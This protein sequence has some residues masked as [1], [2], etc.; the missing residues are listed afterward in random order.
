MYVT[1]S[2]DAAVKAKFFNKK[3]KPHSCTWIQKLYSVNC[4][5]KK[6]RFK[7]RNWAVIQLKKK[8]KKD[9]GEILSGKPKA[10]L[11]IKGVNCS[12]ANAEAMWSNF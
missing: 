6:I 1:H 2:L 9:P 4:Y 10:L 7:W 5:S 8:K 11:L 12:N 3:K